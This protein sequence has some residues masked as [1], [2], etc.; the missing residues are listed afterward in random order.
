MDTPNGHTTRPRVLCPE[1][2][3][4]DG[5][6]LLRKTLDV[7]EKKGLTPEQLIDIIPAYD[8]LV[9]RSETKVTAAL[10]DAARR[11]KVVARA[12]VGVDNVDVPAATKLGI[13]VVNSPSGNIQ[14]A[15]EHT[16]ALLMSMARNVPDACAS[17]KAGKWERSR[18]V[19]V[20]VKGK[21]LG[22]VGLGKVGLIVAR[23]ARGLGMNILAADPYASASVAAAANVQLVESLTDLLPQIDFLT[24]HTPMLASTRGMLSTNELNTMKR[25]A[26]ILNV[27]RGGIIDEEALLLAL[28]SGQIAGAAIDVFT[29]EPPTAD[30]P[31]AKLIAHPKCI[32]T[33]HLGAS[34]VEAQENVSIDVCEQVLQILAGDLPRSAVNAPIILPAEY[35]K[36]QPFV[37]LVEKMGSLYTQ[38]F[39]SPTQPFG[40]N[41][42]TFDLIYQGEIAQMSSAK[43]L[44]AALIKGLTSP[45]SDTEGFN[46][47][48]VNAEMVA[49]ERGIFVNEQKSRDPST[50]AQAY[51]SLVTLVARAPSRAPSPSLSRHAS[52]ARVSSTISTDRDGGGSSRQHVIS[53]YCSDTSPFISR[54]DRFATS[55]APEGT[56]LIC[57]NYDSPGKIGVVG[58]ILGREGVNINFMSVAPATF[59]A[60]DTNGVATPKESTE[61][62]M[63]LGV[64]K[65]VGDD[66]KKE[67][68]V[69]EGFLSVSSVTL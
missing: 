5:L 54:V 12:G 42:N 32:A 46:V 63:I 35:K 38:H 13:V 69:A 16:I 6:T 3:S 29:S 48:I 2:L 57:Q 18:L 26:R 62:L 68:V 58:S 4:P 65:E 61:A 51:S 7:D 8:A 11:L 64:D 43:P 53:G 40:R 49:K 37:R 55:F 19:G 1:K 33:P 14:A 36:L 21:T 67:L 50:Q 45:I 20:E 27:A 28:E 25:G 47:N 24:I 9:V 34:T 39:T 41:M 60:S 17:L 44:F 52:E 30:S 31:A 59:A 22:I 66:I 56:L 10:L 15:A 23:M